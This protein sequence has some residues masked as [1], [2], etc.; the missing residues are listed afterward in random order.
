M[1]A[2]FRALAW[3][4]VI[5]GAVML[6]LYVFAFDVWRVPGDDPLLSAAIQPTLGA[7]D[8]VLVT[9]HATVA[10]GNLLR[11]ADPQAPGR[12]VVARAIAAP[13]ERITIEN[14]VVSIDGRRLPSPRACEERST[15]VT[16]PGTNEDVVLPCA[17]EDFGDITFGTLRLPAHPRPPTT[18]VVE[19][20]KWFLVSDDRHVHLDSRDYG[21]LDPAACQHVVLRIVGAKGF[22]DART[23]LTIVW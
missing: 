12:F 16:D 4:A 1:L 14:D 15:T 8:L 18:A 17:I 19:E 23:R 5:T 6:V 20:G 2:W 7:G 9:R 11:C 22:L 3:L 10:R 13:G 21:Q